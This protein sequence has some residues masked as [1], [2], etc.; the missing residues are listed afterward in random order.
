MSVTG[1][2]LFWLGRPASLVCGVLS[3]QRSRLPWQGGFLCIKSHNHWTASTRERRTLPSPAPPSTLHKLLMQG[4][5]SLQLII[6]EGKTEVVKCSWENDQRRRCVLRK[7]PMHWEIDPGLG[8]SRFQC[9]VSISSLSTSVRKIGKRL[10]IIFL[11]TRSM[12]SVF[13]YGKS[14]KHPTRAEKYLFFFSKWNRQ[15]NG[16]LSDYPFSFISIVLSYMFTVINCF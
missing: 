6:T 4:E 9:L 15:K 12:V 7:Q 1:I 13:F 3:V 14:I 2:H 10:S 11:F 16:E 5:Q 8:C